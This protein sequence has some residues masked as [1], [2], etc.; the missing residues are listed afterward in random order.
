[1]RAI[2]GWLAGSAESVAGVFTREG[3]TQARM[4]DLAEAA[5]VPRAT[6][7]SHFSGKDEV[8]AWLM[9][10]ALADVKA[11]VS[12]AA[13]GTG[14]ARGRL[15]AVFRAQVGVMGRRPAACR[16]LLAN[17]DRAGGL[18]DIAAGVTE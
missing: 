11:A 7:Y 5:G 3:F 17:L 14:D 4:D 18:P 10:S 12:E 13:G 1:M 6:L 2:P 15:E 16:V 9:R 8:L